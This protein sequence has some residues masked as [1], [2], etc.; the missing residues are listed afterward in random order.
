MPVLG[1]AQPGLV[2]LTEH[3]MLPEV[4]GVVKH[5]NVSMLDLSL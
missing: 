2:A 4:Q 3:S 1:L 5:Q